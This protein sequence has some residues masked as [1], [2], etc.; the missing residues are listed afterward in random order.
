MKRGLG[1]PQNRSGRFIII[2][3]IIITIINLFS[4]ISC[5][6]TAF[7]S[8]QISARDQSYLPQHFTNAVLIAH[9]CDL[10]WLCG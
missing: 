4:S 9:S 3:I 2:I 5:E 6:E 7:C 10:L 1:G 8:V